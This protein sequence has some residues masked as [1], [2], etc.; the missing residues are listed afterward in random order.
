MKNNVYDEK[1]MSL[2]L[3]ETHEKAV[4]KIGLPDWIKDLRC[5]H[6]VKKLN[7]NNIREVSLCL[8]ARNIGD[9][10]VQFHCES[11]G[12]MNTLYYRQS[13]ESV[14]AFCDLVKNNKKPDSRPVVE[15]EMY[16]LGYNNLVEI[17]LK[18]KNNGND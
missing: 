16:K 1:D 18:E 15:E 17:F 12:V 10:S 14:D 11:C 13:V 2:S 4:E 3:K 9:V 6:C 5:P 8:N 7:L